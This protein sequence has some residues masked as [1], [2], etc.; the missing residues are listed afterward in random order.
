MVRIV[1]DGSV[2]ISGGCRR[3]VAMDGDREVGSVIY[4]EGPNE[5]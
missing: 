5:G 4:R 3:L 2:G 1:S